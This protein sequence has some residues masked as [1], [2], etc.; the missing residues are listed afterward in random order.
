MLCYSISKKIDVQK[1][2]ILSV[3]SEINANEMK[4]IFCKYIGQKNQ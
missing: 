3:I 4:Y 1:K 2:P